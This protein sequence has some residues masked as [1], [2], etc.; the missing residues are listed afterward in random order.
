MRIYLWL[1]FILIAGKE[2]F[3]PLDGV[4]SDNPLT[5]INTAHL[6]NRE[7]LI[8][9][10]KETSNFVDR[11]RLA[12]M[13]ISRHCG[14]NPVYISSEES[15]ASTI[16]VKN[17]TTFQMTQTLVR[18]GYH[19]LVLDMANATRAGGAT[20]EGAAS[21]EETL[22]R[23]SNLFTALTVA[24]QSDYY[25]LPE[26]GGILIK[27]VTFFRDDNYDF[28]QEPFQADIFASAAYDS[29][30]AHQPSPDGHR[31]YD[32]PEN[33]SDYEYGM[34]AKMRTLLYVALEN[35]HDAL[36]LG[37][38]G[39]GAFRNDPAKVS[40]WY[41][42]VLNEPVFRHAFK[43]VAFAIIHDEGDLHGNFAVF[44]NCFSKG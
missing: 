22:C 39:C 12:S 30:L 13:E 9:V 18:Q 43:V 8:A 28:L 14:G 32:R 40:S 34:K 6:R 25:P 24:A 27:G 42:E 10:F 20:L 44:Q 15:N 7:N 3:L 37:A 26:C 35:G 17:S 29:N 5:E 19:P 4:V 38:F 21:Q 2:S 1:V 23:Q 33:D 16:V 11:H 41:K 31:G 36:V